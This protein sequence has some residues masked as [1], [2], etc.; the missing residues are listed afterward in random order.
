MNSQNIKCLFGHHEY[1]CVDKYRQCIYCRKTQYTD[2]FINPMKST[3]AI[4]HDLNCPENFKIEDLIKLE[5]QIKQPS[6]SS[7]L[8]GLPPNFT[9]K[10]LYPFPIS[11]FN[12][13]GK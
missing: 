6:H 9:S 5:E 13:K 11:K 7:S 12:K 8:T 2:K 10:P 1:V 4:Y 3:E